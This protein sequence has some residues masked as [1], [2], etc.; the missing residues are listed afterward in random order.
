MTPSVARVSQAYATVRQ[1]FAVG[2][3]R[4]RGLFHEHYDGGWRGRIAFNWSFSHVFAA[5]LD[6]YGLGG[7]VTEADIDDLL[8]G[9]RRYWDDRRRTGVPGYSSTVV[10]RFRSSARFFDDNAWCGLN[11][12]RLNRMDRT[13]TE[14]L[15]QAKATFEFAGDEF[16]RQVRAVADT[17]A[18]GGIH[19]QEQ[20][21]NASSEIGTV[22]NAA[23]AQLALRLH[24]A[25]GDGRYL[26]VARGMYSWVNDNM[27][28][29]ASGLFWDHVTPPDCRIDETQWSYNQGL[30]IGANVLLHR[31][32]ADERYRHEA[33]SLAAVALA[34]YDVTRLSEEPVEF[35]VILL[36]NLLLSTTVAN[37][38]S[39]G[40]QVRQRADEYVR[41]V[42]PRFTGT[43]D[44]APTIRIRLIEQ[45][46]IVE[47]VALLCWPE[48][49][50]DLLV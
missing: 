34:A 15:E 11:L 30:M 23:N 4:G 39:L 27:R 7:G 21:G 48:A 16:A 38:A 19:W 25:T 26:D 44:A 42:W 9:L 13:R 45:A 36:R 20:R 37:H 6:L 35:A 1:Q 31:A 18:P 8:V 40:A 47:S 22:A 33:Q 10:K 14:T 43:A 5:A 46:A 50:Y 49:R 32:T 28:D 41:A 17:C 2:G 3:K 24:E 29:P 12:M